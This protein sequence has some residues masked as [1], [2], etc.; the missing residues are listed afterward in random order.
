MIEIFQNENIRIFNLKGAEHGTVNVRINDK[1]RRE[2]KSNNKN[3][4]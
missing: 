3:Y 2:E 1:V 4:H